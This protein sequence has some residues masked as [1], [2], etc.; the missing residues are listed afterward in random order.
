[1]SEAT[2]P[3]ASGSSSEQ[4]LIDVRRAKATRLRER[5]ENPFANDV[6]PR[7]GGTTVD[8]SEL[9]TRAAS[10]KDDAGRFAEDKVKGATTGAI[11]HIRGRVIAFRSAGGLSFLRLR[12]RTGE[13]QLL[14]SEAAMAAAYASPDGSPQIGMI[15]YLFVVA[16]LHA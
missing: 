11:F 7:A 3:Q 2:P 15:R 1:M 8:V 5:N 6:V 10:A 14:C 16:H 12:D 4:A 9:R 13:M